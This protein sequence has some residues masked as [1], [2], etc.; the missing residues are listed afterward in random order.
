MTPNDFEPSTSP[1]DRWLQKEIEKAR[2]TSTSISYSRGAYLPVNEIYLNHL[3]AKKEELHRRYN[4]YQITP[5]QAFGFSR[6]ENVENAPFYPR[7]ISIPTHSG[8]WNPTHHFNPKE[9]QHD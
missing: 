3:L 8:N 9:G 4:P 5:M 6:E 1:W 7:P 2:V